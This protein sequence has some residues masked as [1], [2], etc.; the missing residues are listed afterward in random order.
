MRLWQIFWTVSLLGAGG[1]FAF[2]T[3]IVMV[4]G[5][6]GLREMIRQLSQQQKVDDG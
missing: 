2:I 4:K 1:S 6:K 5:G 3:F